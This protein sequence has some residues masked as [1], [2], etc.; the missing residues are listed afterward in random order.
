MKRKTFADKLAAGTANA[1]DVASWWPCHSCEISNY[2]KLATN[3]KERKYHSDQLVTLSKEWDDRLKDPEELMLQ[4]SGF[5]IS[6]INAAV[7]AD[8]NAIDKLQVALEENMR[9]QVLLLSERRRGFPASTFVE[10]MRDHIRY[11]LE[12]IRHW[13]DGSS[14]RL[15]MC[16]KRRR[17]NAV[18]LGTLMTEWI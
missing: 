13:M 9:E 12:A 10:L 7:T 4:H 18:S 14:R 16:E 2:L 3:P 11:L 1:S 6:L 5:E 8:G 17:Q 15:L